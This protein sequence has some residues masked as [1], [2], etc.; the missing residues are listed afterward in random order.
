MT[1]SHN[2]QHVEQ[3]SVT[4]RQRALRWFEHGF[5]VNWVK[6][7]ENGFEISIEYGSRYYHEKKFEFSYKNNSYYLTQIYTE[8]FDKFNTSKNA[9]LKK[10]LEKVNPSLHIDKF[11]LDEFITSIYDEK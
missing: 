7:I 10:S 9:E 2:E 1:E 11:K 4:A 3:T 5:S 8:A 6:E